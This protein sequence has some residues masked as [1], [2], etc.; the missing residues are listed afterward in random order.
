MLN[1]KATVVGE[2][3]SRRWVEGNV[4]SG[5]RHGG[6]LVVTM[7]QCAALRCTAVHCH[8]PVRDDAPEAW[9]AAA[10]ASQGHHDVVEHKAHAGKLVRLELEM[11][12]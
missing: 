1:K 8:A 2:A 3:L 6:C 9:A 11:G 4:I 12:R 10:E 5:R 7:H